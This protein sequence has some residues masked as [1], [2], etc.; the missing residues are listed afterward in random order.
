MNGANDD[1]DLA[2][3]D[4]ATLVRLIL[5]STIA[6]ADVTLR[7]L[8]RRE[9][10]TVTQRNNSKLLPFSLQLILAPPTRILLKEAP[11]DLMKLS[12]LSDELSLNST[13]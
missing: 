8:C 2:L 7:P 12:M 6:H 10:L 11:S 9:T 4:G 13:I 1:L 5:Y 3:V